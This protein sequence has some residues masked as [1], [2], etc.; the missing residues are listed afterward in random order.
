[1]GIWFGN[2][3]AERWIW[4]TV[5]CYRLAV[6]LDNKPSYFLFT[7]FYRD[8]LHSSAVLDFPQEIFLSFFLLKKNVTL[9]FPS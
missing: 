3:P 7:F 5:T 6:V 2:P 8:F 9:F 4:Q 1:M